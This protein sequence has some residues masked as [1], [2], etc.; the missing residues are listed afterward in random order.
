MKRR[1]FALSSAMAAACVSWAAG[2]ATTDPT[3]RQ[4]QRCLDVPANA[5]TA[6]QVGCENAAEA[7]DR[8]MN[9]AY[10]ALLRRLTPKSHR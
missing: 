6:G 4:L 3:E 10:A 8:R 9:L 1:N 2:A 5:S 7:Y